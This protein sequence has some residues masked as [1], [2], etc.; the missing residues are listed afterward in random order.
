M[1]AVCTA[2]VTEVVVSSLNCGEST[3]TLS[4]VETVVIEIKVGRLRNSRS[5][6]VLYV[7]T[8]QKYQCFL[9]YSI[10]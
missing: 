7:D 5:C 4:I 10:G 6:R 1:V 2:V 3:C 8:E 9:S